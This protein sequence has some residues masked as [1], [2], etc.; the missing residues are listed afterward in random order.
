MFVQLQFS[1]ELFTRC[2]LSTRFYP[3]V[4]FVT[5]RVLTRRGR[6]TNYSWGHDV[7][8]KI[9][10][11]SS[12]LR[13]RYIRLGCDDRNI[14][15][16]HFLQNQRSKIAS[17]SSGPCKHRTLRKPRLT[18]SSIHF[19]SIDWRCLHTS[20]VSAMKTPC[21]SDYATIKG[22]HSRPPITQR[23]AG[24]PKQIYL[25]LNRKIADKI[26]SFRNRCVRFSRELLFPN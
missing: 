1:H 21:F 4:E 9:I 25:W 20:L 2:F 8:H 13:T 18:R 6:R 24:R 23:A 19:A 22:P 26:F 14:C 5:L 15:S 12:K 16:F 10:F 7:C 11:T 17:S 3:P